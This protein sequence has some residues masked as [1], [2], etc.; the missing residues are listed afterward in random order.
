MIISYYTF[1]D[2]KS[3]FMCSY[4]GKMYS[5]VVNLRRHQQ[6]HEEP[7]HCHC[8]AIFTTKE[9][10]KEHENAKHKSLY[11]C[12]K[13]P[14]L[15]RFSSRSGLFAHNVKAHKADTSLKVRIWLQFI[16]LRMW[17]CRCRSNFVSWLASREAHEESGV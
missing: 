17:F 3:T 15:R 11:F 14:N 2:D 6:I 4:C 9:A 7:Q 8:G 12:K 16:N 10:L 5:S 1:S 13:C